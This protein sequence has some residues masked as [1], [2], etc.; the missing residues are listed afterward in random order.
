MNSIFFAT[1]TTSR[2]NISNSENDP[3]PIPDI[4]W[5]KLNEGSGTS[6]NNE[7][8]GQSDATTNASWSGGGLNFNGSSQYASSNSSISYSNANVLT[9][10]GWWNFNDD[11]TLQ[12]L[13]E[14]SPI[15]DS[16][17][18]A[19]F[20]YISAG[21]I[22]AGCKYNSGLRF[23]SFATPSIGVSTNIAFVFD[24]A[25]DNGDGSFGNIKVYFNA[26]LQSGTIVSSLSTIAGPFDD[27]IFYI[28]SRN[29]ST[30]FYNGTL[31]DLRIYDGELTNPQISDIYSAGPQ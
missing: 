27:Y 4:V 10:C 11:T 9:I 23:E 31:D 16:N 25:I 7:V 14:S 20:A 18:G 24:N 13:F 22:F 3:G 15:I 12:I 6:L 30:F 2:V 26:N 28:S 29:N 19:F 8:V 5:Y 17:N 1:L 21:Q